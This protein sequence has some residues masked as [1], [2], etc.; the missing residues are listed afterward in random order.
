MLLI[1]KRRWLYCF[2]LIVAL[3]GCGS[4]GI[5]SSD[6]QDLAAAIRDI[7]DHGQLDDYKYVAQRL[8]INITAG[9]LET[10][11]D[12]ETHYYRGNATEFFT[13]K[14][15]TERFSVMPK[16][17]RYRISRASGSNKFRGM[18]S[19]D[20]MT[21]KGCIDQTKMFKVFGFS[22]PVPNPHAKIKSFRYFFKRGQDYELDIIYET[23]DSN[24]AATFYLFQNRT[25]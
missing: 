2:S 13:D 5:A 22:T 8:G 24:C 3:F 11:S 6:N 12:P 15:V 9:P 18:L 20:N 4:T 25:T 16:D 7:V 10:L 14:S 17:F 19:L 21:S 1:K 23:V